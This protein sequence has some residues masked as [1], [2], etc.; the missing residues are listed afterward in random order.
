MTSSNGQGVSH[1]KHRGIR[2]KKQQPKRWAGKKPPFKVWPSK[3]AND[4][5]SMPCPEH[6]KAKSTIGELS[7]WEG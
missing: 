2:R 5:S 6:C 7:G 3:H 4:K 1:K